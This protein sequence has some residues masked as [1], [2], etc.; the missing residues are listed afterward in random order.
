MGK[1]YN[2]VVFLVGLTLIFMCRINHSILSLVP[3]NSK[4]VEGIVSMGGAI[5]M[6]IAVINLYSLCEIEK[7][8]PQDKHS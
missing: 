8:L 5:L 3:L 6:I 4:T 1:V 7:S 2:T